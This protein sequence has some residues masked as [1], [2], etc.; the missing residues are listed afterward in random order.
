MPS[1]TNFFNYKK[2]QKANQKTG[3]TNRAFIAML[4]EITAYSQPVGDLGADA[5]TIS[6]AHTFATDK[7]FIECYALPKSVEGDTATNGDMGAINEE[8][9][10]KVFIPGDTPELQTMIKSLKNDDLIVVVEDTNESGGKRQFGSD[11]C[12]IYVKSYKFTSGKQGTEGKKGYELELGG[13]PDRYFA[14]YT[15]VTIE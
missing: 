14:D 2:A 8:Q 4:S 7:G 3:Y 6:V 12:P 15:V 11:K 9:T 1:T 5:A 10:V 13:T